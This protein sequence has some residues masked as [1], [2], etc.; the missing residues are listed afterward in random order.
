[1][2]PFYASLKQFFGDEPPVSMQVTGTN[3][4]LGCNGVH[5][6]DLFA[7]L[8]ED[9]E[10]KYDAH[11]LDSVVHPS[12]REGFYEFSGTLVGRHAG[13]Q[14]ELQASVT[15]T[16]RHL[17]VLRS[18]SKIAIVDEVGGVARLLAE[19]GVWVEQQFSMP[20]QSQLTGIIASEVLAGR[21]PS[22]PDFATSS[23][24]HVAFIE[25]LLAHFNGVSGTNVSACPIT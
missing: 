23:R 16:A 14:I 10:L 24:I 4:G 2:F 7:Y 1:M 15:G 18:S 12:K 21:A 8:S 17:I 25:P 9:S 5:F 3:W 19:D 13:K 22:L 20:Y 6:A 11:L